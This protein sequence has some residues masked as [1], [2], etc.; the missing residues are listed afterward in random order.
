MRM[1]VPGRPV[2]ETPATPPPIPVERPTY[3][4][5]FIP[6]ELSMWDYFVAKP[7]LPL[8]DSGALCDSD[9]SGGSDNEDD[10]DAFLSDTQMT[11]HSEPNSYSWSLIRLVMVK[12]ALH[13]VKTFLPL[14]GLDFTELPVTSPLANAVLK[15][16]ENWEQI[17]L[18]KMNKFDGPPPNY[19]NTY[20]TDL[21]AGGGPA[22][23][24]HKAMLEPDNTPFKSKH[25]F[26]FP[27]RRLWHFLVKQE[28]LQ[29]TL[30][31]YIFTKKRKQSE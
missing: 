27:A 8:S 13:N 30:I 20:P 24:R 16:L 29:E 22:I 2:K 19:I 18:E 5:K 12:L 21:S 1:L 15:T 4:E 23:L 28:V 31:R 7:F 9:E 17:L 25:R 11:E 26:S 10:D 14:T 3:K 6:P